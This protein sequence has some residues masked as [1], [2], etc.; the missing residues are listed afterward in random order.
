MAA[1]MRGGLRMGSIFDEDF[2]TLE[3][4]GSLL[5][6]DGSSKILLFPANSQRDFR[7]FPD[8]GQRAWPIPIDLVRKWPST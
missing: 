5:L 6:S 2:L 1:V 4:V 7:Q 3:G 8:D